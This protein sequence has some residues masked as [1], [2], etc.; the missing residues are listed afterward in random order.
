[1]YAFMILVE[2]AWR[3]TDLDTLPSI[4]ILIGRA[5]GLHTSLLLVKESIGAL[6]FIIQGIIHLAVSTEGNLVTFVDV[7]EGARGTSAGINRCIPDLPIVAVDSWRE[8]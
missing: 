7:G 6:T 8:T 4:P 3:T 5:V 2:G 1:M